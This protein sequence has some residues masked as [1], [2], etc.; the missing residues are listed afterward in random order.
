MVNISS[1]ILYMAQN[2]GFLRSAV[3]RNCSPSESEKLLQVE[4]GEG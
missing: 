2:G 3:C 4:S 1:T